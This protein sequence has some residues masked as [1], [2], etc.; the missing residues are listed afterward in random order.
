MRRAHLIFTAGAV[1]ALACE[2]PSLPTLVGTGADRAAVAADDSHGVVAKAQGEGV[3]DLRSANAGLMSFQFD[4]KQRADGSAD[5]EFWQYRESAA[6]TVEFTGRVTC[7]TFDP[8]NH[9]AWVGG[10]ILE[11][12]STN[13]AFQVDT[14]H[15]AGMDIWF[16]VVDYAD[17]AVPEPDRSTVFGFK[18]SAGIKTTPEYCQLQPWPDTPTR[19]ARTF[20]VLEGDIKVKTH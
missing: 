20:P 12:R 7:V 2:Q 17:A 9:R 15:L 8:A 18:W 3:V 13:P 14:L 4:A 6:G 11:N 16:R 19:D 5:G 10:I 1:A